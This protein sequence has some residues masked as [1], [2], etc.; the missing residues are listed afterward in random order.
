MTTGK[1]IALTRWAFVGKVMFLLFNK[2]SMLVIAFLPKSKCLLISWLQLPS[3]VILEPTKIKSVM[4]FI[5][6]PSLFH[7]VMGSDAMIFILWTLSF[8]P[9]FSHSFTLIKRLFSSSCKVSAEKESQPGSQARKGKF[10]RGKREGD[11][12]LR[13][14]SILLF[15]W[16][17]YTPPMKNSEGMVI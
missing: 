6:F 4:V 14:T 3:A 15:W 7:E 8:K 11:W 12:L 2:L 16:S 1:A 13:R 17:P 10:I 9:A 5:V